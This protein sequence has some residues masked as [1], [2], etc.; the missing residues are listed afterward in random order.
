[1]NV[2]VAKSCGFCR[3][4]RQAVDTAMSVPVD[5]TYVLGE[6][7]HNEEV[8]SKISE[9]GITTVQSLSEVPSGATLLIRSH[10]VGKETY[11]A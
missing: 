5:N 11:D 7:I 3:G 9:R 6:L 10:G 2:I 4:V 1:M 8:V